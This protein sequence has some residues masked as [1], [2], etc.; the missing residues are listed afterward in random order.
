MEIL[1]ERRVLKKVLITGCNGFVGWHLCRR[2]LDEGILVRGVSRTIEKSNG[3]FEQVCVGDIGPYTDWNDAMSGVDT[4]V[5]LA[6]L[7]HVMD[8]IASDL[9]SAFV[10]VNSYGTETL[11]KAAINRGVSRLVFISSVKVN[12][13]GTSK[14]NS[15]AYTEID[16]PLPNDAYALSKW[17]AE[18]VLNKIASETGFEIVILRPPLVYGPKVKANFLRLLKVVE[19]GIPLPL[20]SVKNQRSLIYLDNLVDAIVTCIKHP[21]ASGQT[22]FVSDGDDVSTPDLIR[23]IGSALGRPARLFPFPP[24]MLKMVGITT[25]KSATIDT[26]L[27]SLTIN[28]SKIRREL[29]WKAPFSMDQGLRETAKWYMEKAAQ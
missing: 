2:M 3:P 11:A 23:R 12:G 29:D 17:K 14:K 8:D 13:D 22:Y 9:E 4:I 15:I 7:T 1:R 20:A 19:R 28:C 27:R 26:L 6:A 5:H 16:S 18:C 24:L 25:G 21:K 10:K